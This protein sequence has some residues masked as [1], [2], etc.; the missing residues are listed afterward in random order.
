M[1]TFKIVTRVPAYVSYVYY[2]DADTQEQ[3]I[4][5][6]YEGTV[7]AHDFTT[8]IDGEEEVVDVSN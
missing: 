3:A 2:I 4:D 1:T 8:D 5:M 6:I 7:D